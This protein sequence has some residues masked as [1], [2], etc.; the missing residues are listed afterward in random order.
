MKFQILNP[1]IGSDPEYGAIDSTGTPRS[2]VDFLPGTKQEPFDLND[3]V[4][5]QV[6]NVGAECC[7]PPCKNEEEFVNYMTMAKNLTE[8]KLR[9]MN[10]DLSL[11]SVSSQKY[12]MEELNSPTAQM[13]GCDPSY[14]VYTQDRSPRP[15]PE[16]VGNLR[17]FGFHIHVGFK[18][19]EGVDQFELIDKL[20]RA[21]DIQLGV[22]SI[23]IDRDE[24]RR[25][26][27]G[28]AGDLRFRRIEDILIIEYRTLGGF[29]HSSE[30]LL[31]F[32]YRQT[33]KAVEMVNNWQDEYENV[34]E[35]IRYTI[36]TGDANLAK[37][38]CDNFKI[39]INATYSSVRNTPEGSLQ[40]R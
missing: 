30:D 5:C 35:K 9:E 3:F 28:N 32:V 4:S 37:Q 12:S 21:M 11:V 23:L 26:I 33:I 34:G 31:R 39:E 29:M 7:I 24:D 6:D 14:C 19:E 10:P 1:T 20:I 2:V 38:F 36:D 15:S 40:S 17:S 13:F 16:E 22:P 8:Q 25:K 18:I 27:Y